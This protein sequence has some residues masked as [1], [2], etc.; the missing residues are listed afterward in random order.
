MVL[1]GQI[2]SILADCQLFC[3]VKANAQKNRG[4]SVKS[5]PG[6]LVLILRAADYG[7]EFTSSPFRCPLRVEEAVRS[8]CLPGQ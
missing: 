6:F 4:N 5:Y 1:R 3:F 7:A 2:F 8:C